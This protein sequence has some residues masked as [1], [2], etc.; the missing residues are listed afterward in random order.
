MRFLSSI[1]IHMLK[2]TLVALSKYERGIGAKK[3]ERFLVS[4][5]EIILRFPSGI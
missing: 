5:V 1:E 4:R 3:R 2:M